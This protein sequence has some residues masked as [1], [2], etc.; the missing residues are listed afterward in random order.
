[1]HARPSPSAIVFAASVAAV[2]ATVGPRAQQASVPSIDDLLNL[3]RVASPALSP[4]GR[5]VAYTVRE[6]NWDENAYETEIWLARRG[7]RRAAP[8]DQRRQVEPAAGLEPGQPDAR[9]H[10]RS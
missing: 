6:T 10:L 5:W 7:C 8:A 1:M 3:K 4:D 2:V 9:V